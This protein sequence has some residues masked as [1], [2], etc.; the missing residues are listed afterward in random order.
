VF[1]VSDYRFSIKMNGIAAAEE[2]EA[3]EQRAYW[4]GKRS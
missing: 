1:E 2:R 3:E 4:Q